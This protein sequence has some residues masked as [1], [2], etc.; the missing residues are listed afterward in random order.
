MIKVDEL[1]KYSKELKL[2]YVEDNKDTRESTLLILENFFSDI[3]IAVDGVD[4]LEKFKSNDIEIVITDINMPNMN[5]LEMSKKIKDINLDVPIFVFSAHNEAGFFMDAIKIGV[6]GYLIKPFNM[7]QFMQSLSKC[8]TNLNLKKE[9]LE[10]KN[11]LEEKVNIQVEELRHKDNLL[12]QNS[13][14]AAMGEMIDAIAHQWKQPLGVIKLQSEI[15]DYE[16]D[17]ENIDKEYLMKSTNSIKR[18]IDHLTDTID[19]FRSFFRPNTNIIDINLKTLFN[20][21]SILLHD[22]LL[23]FNVDIDIKCDETISIK[24]NENEIKHLL[25]NLINN[26]KDEMVKSEVEPMQRV[27]NIGCESIQN[28][29]VIKVKD[30]G[31]GVPEDIINDIFRPHF[32]TK[33]DEGGTGIGLYMCQQIVDKYGGKMDVSNDNGAVFRIIFNKSNASTCGVNND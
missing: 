29:I 16:L 9:N 21:I 5:G 4:G 6:E 22:E 20:S 3:T 13:K 30:S 14:M 2:L 1:I 12:V 7:E 15:I 18:Q 24:A 23:K 11:N 10:Y 27:I 31:K 33:K 26:G 19:E 25:I 17:V 32:T 28:D 8:I